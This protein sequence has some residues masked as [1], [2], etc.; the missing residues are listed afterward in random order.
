M[1]DDSLKAYAIGTS[2]KKILL[3][4]AFILTPQWVIAGNDNLGQLFTSPEQRHALNNFRDKDIVQNDDVIE[5]SDDSGNIRT[6]DAVIV[7]GIIKRSHGDETIWINGVEIKNK[8]DENG[9]RI[10]KGVGHDG[11]ISV[12]V[13]SQRIVKLKPGQRFLADDGRV[14]E[15]YLPNMINADAVQ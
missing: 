11:R 14:T 4:I 1:D 13:P 10:V 6:H 5:R 15:N 9:V 3:L 8:A 7:N 12:A 2:L